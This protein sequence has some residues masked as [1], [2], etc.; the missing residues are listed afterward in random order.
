MGCTDGAAST[1]LRI[2]KLLVLVAKRKPTREINEALSLIRKSGGK[3]D[4]MSLDRVC[5]LVDSVQAR[6]STRELRIVLNTL[7]DLRTS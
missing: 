2:Q 7:S 6:R 5:Q 4:A 3:L 1:L